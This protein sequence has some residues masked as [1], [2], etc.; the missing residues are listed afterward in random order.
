M[1]FRLRHLWIVSLVGTIFFLG[2]LAPRAAKDNESVKTEYAQLVKAGRYGEIEK[3]ILDA[4]GKAQGGKEI[5]ALGEVLAVSADDAKDVLDIFAQNDSVTATTTYAELLLWMA[6]GDEMPRWKRK[7]RETEPVLMPIE[8]IGQRSATLLDHNDPFVRGIAEWAIAVS[9]GK[10]NSGS[11]SIWPV[12]DAPGWYETWIQFLDNPEFVLEIDYVR[13][14]ATLGIHRTAEKLAESA[15]R[16]LQRSQKAVDWF[17]YSSQFDEE[18]LIRSLN[19]LENAHAGLKQS[20]ED[21]DLTKARIQWIQLRTAARDIVFLNPDIQFD[22][23]LF[24]LRHAAHDGPNITAG[25][26]SYIY[27]PG[28]DIVVKSGFSPGDTARP[29]IDGKLPPG[30]VRGIELWWDADKLVFGYAK[31]PEYYDE[32]ILESDQGF[33]D[34]KH[35]LSEPVHIYEIDIDGK[36]LKQITDHEY[37]SDVEPTYLPTGDVVFCS[38]RSNFGSQ[39]S[40]HFFQNKKIVNLYRVSRDGGNPRPLSNNKDFDRYPHVLD[41]GELIFT[42]WE[43]QER[44]LYQ[45]HNL[46]TSHPDGTMSDAIYKQHINSGPMALRDA[47]QIPGSHKMAAIACGHHEW[48]QGALTIIDHHRGVNN[49]RGMRIVTPEIS[50]RE[51]GIG[52]G[53]AVDEGGVMDNGGLYQQPYPLSEQSFLVSYSYH[54]PRSDSNANNFAL[55]YIDVWGN[56][57][58]IHREPVL[59]AVYPIPVAKRKQPPIIPDIVHPEKQEAE[60]YVANVYSGVPEI[61]Y[62]TIKHIRISQPTHWPTFQT[63]DRVTD[64]NHLHYTPSGSWARTLGVWTWTPARVIGTVPV[65]SDGSAYFKVPVAAPVY[66]QA[67]DENS[68][69]VRRMRT[70]VTL[71]PGELRGCTGCHETRDETPMTSYRLPTAAP[72]KPSVPIPPS[73][74][75]EELPDYERH[76]QPI[77]DKYCVSCHG[78]TDPA[79]GLEFSG[80]KFDGYCQSY[81][82]M[83]GL[84]ADEPTP[85]DETWSFNLFYPEAPKPDRDR[86]SLKQMEKNEFPGQLISIS[87]RFSDAS[88]TQPMEFGS[89]KSEFILALLEEDHQKRVNMSQEDWIDLVTWVDLNAPYWGSFVDKEPV[90]EG[91]KP[92]R[93]RIELPPPFGPEVA[94]SE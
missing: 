8:E 20:V 35:G 75:N 60:C 52:R 17:Q 53:K 42:R 30:H 90:R 85:I 59:S 57:E 70:F 65:R 87:N 43:Y 81:R 48:A 62:G 9:V 3:R 44:H 94:V 15:E 31:Q 80:R 2:L 38:D 46:W 40:G 39:C 36:G 55:Y 25:A 49:F 82:T 51:G 16:I 58:L 33:D 10:A 54:L 72:E 34:K 22:E 6:R 66:F 13:Q 50:P 56:R 67:L 45:T 83:F 68:M 37:N 74:G 63:G 76:I 23:I 71:Q 29:L 14:G 84:S 64:F 77:L 5:D 4:T 41:S 19:S 21:K 61:E 28:G 26:K 24:G 88:I 11:L 12:Q 93:V 69:E 7:N 86:D 1:I 91:E 18:T 89:H 92:V 47:R 32:F 78:E 73:W 79:A 27:K